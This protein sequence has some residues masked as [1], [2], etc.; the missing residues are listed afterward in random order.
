ML[1]K[2]VIGEQPT[3]LQTCSSLIGLPDV[4]P[5]NEDTTPVKL[6]PSP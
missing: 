1:S 3:T 4:F 5:V 6:L 2:K